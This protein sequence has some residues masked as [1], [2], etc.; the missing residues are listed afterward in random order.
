M[1]RQGADDDCQ[2]L[3]EQLRAVGTKR[4]DEIADIYD[5]GKFNVHLVDP[6]DEDLNYTGA[7][8]DNN[9]ATN[10]M[11]RTMLR[12]RGVLLN[13]GLADGDLLAVAG[14]EALVHVQPQAVANDGS[15][16]S[17]FAARVIEHT[18]PRDLSKFNEGIYRALTPGL[19]ATAPVFRQYMA[20]IN[21]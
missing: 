13:N 2:W 5:Q 16:L 11:G 9:P 21:P 8:T 6:D 4:F 15:R 19:Q 20:Y 7:N 12:G 17:D 10:A 14:H 18:R 1:C 3:V